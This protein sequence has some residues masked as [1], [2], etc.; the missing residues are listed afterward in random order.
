MPPKCHHDEL[1]R[2]EGHGLE[3]FARTSALRNRGNHF[4]KDIGCS[5]AIG[6]GGEF[7]ARGPYGEH[8]EALVEVEVPPCPTQLIIRSS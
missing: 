7:L 2:D 8:T 5:L 6:P 1:R 3:P 4:G